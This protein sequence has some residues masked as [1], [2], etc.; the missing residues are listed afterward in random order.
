MLMEILPGTVTEI[1]LGILTEIPLTI[2]TPGR[3][4]QILSM[5]HLRKIR[6]GILRELQLH[7]L[8]E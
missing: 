2:L 8:L 7:P 4:L 3:L 1:P 6:S 5:E